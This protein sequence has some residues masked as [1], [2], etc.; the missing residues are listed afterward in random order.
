MEFNVNEIFE[1]S[2]LGKT[3][4][5]INRMT[6]NVYVNGRI[7]N[8]L[9]PEVQEFILCHEEGHYQLQTRDELEADAYASKR[10]LGSRKKS[11]KSSIN[12]LESF[13]KDTSIFN[14]QRI[15]NQYIRA[16]KYDYIVFGNL[17][18]KKQLNL[19]NN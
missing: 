10:F 4:A 13:L 19:L 18:A 8:K 12:A 17:K 2:D 16:L 7:W 14:D 15:H 3:P 5:R 6:G 1:V 9:S 11:L